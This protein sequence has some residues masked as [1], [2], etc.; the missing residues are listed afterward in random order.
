MSGKS[1]E[2]DVVVIKTG[3]SKEEDAK[4][5]VE[6]A[7]IA[8]GRIDCAFN[9]AG[10]HKEFVPATDFLEKA[11]NAPDIDALSKML[12]I[13]ILNNKPEFNPRFIL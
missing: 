4:A 2:A 13:S 9:N 6:G 7:I 11:V 3:V 10:I 1:N 12:T 5:L 8:F